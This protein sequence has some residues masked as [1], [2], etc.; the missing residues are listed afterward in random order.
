MKI[1]DDVFVFVKSKC[2]A[3]MFIL[4]AL[5]IRQCLDVLEGLLSDYG[6]LTNRQLQRLFL[7]SLMWS[8]GAVLEHEDRFKLEEFILKH[9][10]KMRKFASWIEFSQIMVNRNLHF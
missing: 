8:L 7:F 5:Y 10:S 4:E 1:Y 3:K 2:T 6:T 9:P